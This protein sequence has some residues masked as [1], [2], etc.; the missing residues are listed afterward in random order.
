ML[1][2]LSDCSDIWFYVWTDYAATQE[3]LHPGITKSKDFLYPPILPIIYYEG[4][5]QWTSALHFKDRVFMSDIFE[6]FIPDYKYSG[7]SF[8]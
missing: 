2:C 4:T 5:G 7:R 6:E 8:E 1:T 3:K